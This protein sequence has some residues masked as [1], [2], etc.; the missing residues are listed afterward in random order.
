[1]VLLTVRVPI[2]GLHPSSWP[3]LPYIGSYIYLYIAF[4]IR[5]SQQPRTHP[6]MPSS[7]AGSTFDL[8]WQ[9]IADSISQLR[10]PR[11]FRIPCLSA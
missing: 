4:C 10:R 9:S 6:C 7:K 3:C 5:T 8:T 2:R 11:T 1:M